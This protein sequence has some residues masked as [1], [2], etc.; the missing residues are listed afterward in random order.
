MSD[1]NDRDDLADR[2]RSKLKVLRFDNN[3]KDLVESEKPDETFAD[4]G[5]LE[6][7]KKKYA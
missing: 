5:G 1:H 6:D 7:V 4:V 3:G 2:R